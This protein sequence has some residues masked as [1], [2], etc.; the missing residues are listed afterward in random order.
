[1][2]VGHV[3]QSWLAV[4]LRCGRTPRVFYAS[5]CFLHDCALT[6]RSYQG[7]TYCWLT[8]SW[9]RRA[10]YLLTTCVAM[11]VGSRSY[12]RLPG[13]WCLVVVA[14][15]SA[16]VVVQSRPSSYATTTTTTTT[17]RIGPMRV[18]PQGFCWHAS[19]DRATGLA[20]SRETSYVQRPS[21][22]TTEGASSTS[23]LVRTEPFLAHY[24]QWLCR[25]RVTCGLLQAVPVG[26]QGTEIRLRGLGL[27][28][29][30]L[31]RPVGQ[32]I[33]VQ[34]Q[35]DGGSNTGRRMTAIQWNY[36]IAGGLLAA[37]PGGQLVVQLSSTTHDD[38]APPLLHIESRLVNYRPRI[39]G[40]APTNSWRT[41]LYLGSQSAIHGYVMWRF[42]HH[43]Q[44]AIREGS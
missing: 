1:M 5:F 24:P 31:G 38:D 39:V 34:K 14:L 23:L 6:D 42:H 25:A 43:V 41:A 36:A 15:S 12:G 27:S 18:W 37:A 4:L 21:A 29:L 17:W 35:G 32:R 19:V 26:K 11:R 7:T 3:P 30:T 9:I 2:A 20:A 44:R 28:L 22:G 33:Q 16:V 40:T 13:W 8:R 10:D